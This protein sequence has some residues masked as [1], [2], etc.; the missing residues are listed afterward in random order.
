MIVIDI[1]TEFV[2]DEMKLP[3]YFHEGDACVDLQANIE[4]P[5]TLS[6][7]EQKL[8]PTGLYV[9]LPQGNDY[10]NWVL[11]IVS[12]S[13]L[14]NKYGLVVVN[15]PGKIDS[16]F[17]GMIHVILKNSKLSQFTVEPGMRIAQAQLSKAYKISWNYV[18]ELDE[19]V[20][21]AG[22]FGSTGQ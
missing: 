8:I 4:E 3:E 6:F 14:A 7:G 16:H 10:Y 15:R 13:G 9:A 1:R 19:T 20:R 21:G 11:D 2:N 5:I 22:A 12:R 17:R 18:D